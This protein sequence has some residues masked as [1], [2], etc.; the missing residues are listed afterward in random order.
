M[1]LLPGTREA[2]KPY[3]WTTDEG[4]LTGF[5]VDYFDNVCTNCSVDWVTLL[6]GTDFPSDTRRGLE[7]VV[8]LTNGVVDAILADVRAQTH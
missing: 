2:G 5:F 3:I 8:A 4:V 1:G 7:P 6:A